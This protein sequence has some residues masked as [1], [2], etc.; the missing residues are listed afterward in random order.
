MLTKKIK[1]INKESLFKNMVNMFLMN[2]KN[3]KLS[4]D[5]ITLKKKKKFR[6]I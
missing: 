6:K 2:F 4:M 5:L 3:Q 1:K